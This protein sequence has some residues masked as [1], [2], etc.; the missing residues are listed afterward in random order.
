MSSTMTL[1]MP[2]LPQPRLSTIP[3]C[4]SCGND[5]SLSFIPKDPSADAQSLALTAAQKQIQDLEAQVRLLNQKA[6]AAVD[7]WADYEDELGKLKAELR[8]RNNST[9]AANSNPRPQTPTLRE[10]PSS[11]A[12]NSSVGSPGAA[13]T[14]FAS[15]ASSRISAYLSR[16]ST[17]NLKAQQPAAGHQSSLSTSSLLP[18]GTPPAASPGHQSS[19]STSSLAPPRT[20]GGTPLTLSLSGGK[21]T[22]TPGHS[23]APSSDDLLEA[24]TREQQLRLAAE[25]KLNDSSKE[26]EDLSVTLFEQANEMVATERRAR[27]RLEERVGELERRENEK[28]RRLERLEQAMGRIERARA[29][30]NS[31]ADASVAEKRVSA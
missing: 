1:T 30:L 15:A 25:G 4:P 21:V 8:K 13:V 26:I 23:P 28:K 19:R 2:A 3:C 27:A 5:L 7:R 24:L 12:T 9:P 18:A 16:K 14:S 6:T 22:W 17:P 10:T 31:G 20:P 29:L 11:P